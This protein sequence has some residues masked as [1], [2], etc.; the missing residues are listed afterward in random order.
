MA[1]RVDVAQA[2][3]G[4]SADEWSVRATDTVVQV[5]TT[6]HDK[7]TGPLTTVAR[8]IVYGLAAAILGIAALVLVSILAIRLIVIIPFVGDV[9]VA[10]LAVG[11]V[12]TLAGLVL[13]R[14][15]N[16]TPREG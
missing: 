6:V 14:L 11:L 8:A 3:A 12:F 16:K 5:V 10:Y 15:A 9:W 1:D 7:T 2:G 13:W 4:S